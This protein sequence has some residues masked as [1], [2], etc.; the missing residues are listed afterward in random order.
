MRYVL[1]LVELVLF[2]L[3]LCFVLL[4][5]GVV[6]VHYFLGQWTTALPWLLL[7]TLFVGMLLGA[8]AMCGPWYRATRKVAS[9]KRAGSTSVS[10]KE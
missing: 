6:T 10:A 1:L 7:L 3:V 4:N 9:L 5:K 8:L 2:A